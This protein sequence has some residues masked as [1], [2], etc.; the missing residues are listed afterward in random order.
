MPFEDTPST[1]EGIKI[2]KKALSGLETE[3]GR[4]AGVNFTPLP[5]D[6]MLV[7]SPKCG[8]TLICQI[9][10]SLRSGGDMS[11]EEINLV[12]PCLEMGWDYGYRDLQ[13]AQKYSPRAFKTHFWRPH[14]PQTPG[15]RYIFTVRD[16]LDAGI[17]FYHFFEG[18]MF[19]K[20]T[21]SIEEFLNEFILMRGAPPTPMQN[22]SWWH[23]LIS[24]YP[25]RNDPDV[26]F[27]FF[28]DIVADLQGSVNRI[29]DFLGLAKDDHALRALAAQ[30]ASIEHMRKFITK[31]DEH[32]LKEARNEACGLHPRAGLD[33][34]DN[35]KVREGSV[36]GG[37]KALTD[38]TMEAMQEK[39]NEVVLPVTGYKS[40]AELRAG[41]NAEQGRERKR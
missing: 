15:A 38:L 14:C 9:V 4:M 28:E 1:S 41:V 30:Q 17:S 8:T 37:K 11:F 20:G 16:P 22:A 23:N 13:A 33:T 25:H 3:Q 39:W 34:G 2:L 26:L 7:T 27:L 10:Q 24:W 36:G 18:W 29:A 6:V 5:G 35:A 40:Y 31:Y 21:V 32:M 12:I 19:E